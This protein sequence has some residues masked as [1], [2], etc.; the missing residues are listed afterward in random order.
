M[1]F[2][3]VVPNLR[4][5]KIHFVGL[6]NNMSLLLFTQKEG[7]FQNTQIAQPFFWAFEERSDIYYFRQFDRSLMTVTQCGKTIIWSQPKNIS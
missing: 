6:D 2:Y 1:T 3:G 4:P 7:D 5:I